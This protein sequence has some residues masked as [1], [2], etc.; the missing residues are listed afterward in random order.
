MLL[1]IDQRPMPEHIVQLETGEV[2]AFAQNQQGHGE[3]LCFVHGYSDSR[4]TWMG[5]MEDIAARAPDL[6]LIALDL[7]EHGRSRA[8]AGTASAQ[9]FDQFSDPTYLADVVARFLE[10]I[11]VPKATIVGHSMGGLIAQ[12]LALRWPEKVERLILVATA[13]RGVG[14]H[15]LQSFRDRVLEGDWLHRSAARDGRTPVRDLGPDILP[16]IRAHWAVETGAPMPLL[17]GIATAAGNLPIG[18][19]RV[20]LDALLRT[21]HRAALDQLSKPILVLSGSADPIFPP[22]LTV[23]LADCLGRSS[24]LAGRLFAKDYGAGAITAASDSAG[25]GHN[26]P[27][28]LPE[29]LATDIIAFV[30]EGKPT[31]AN[32]RFDVAT[33]AFVV[34]AT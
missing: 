14:N 26:V 3:V 1:L 28:A 34:D 19:W 27:W 21:D 8:K 13:A 29:L 4:L 7:P 24:S 32:C 33:S 2:I 10:K 23:E 16:W 18:L 22:E 30:Q 31:T 17:D 20:T 12:D 5:T 15:Q 9:D 6:R 11:D 25:V